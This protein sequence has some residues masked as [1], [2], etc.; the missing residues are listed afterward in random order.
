MSSWLIV[1]V[2][3][4]TAFITTWA[5]LKYGPSQGPD[6]S[7]YYPPQQVAQHLSPG[8][9]ALQG[10]WQLAAGG[11]QI[12]V[13]RAGAVA[14]HADRG[15]CTNCHIVVSSRQEPIP[16]I[17]ASSAMPHEYRGVCSNCHLLAS[18]SGLNANPYRMQ[19][20]PPA[21]TMV[22]VRPVVTPGTVTPAR[23]ATEGEWMGLEVT[24]ITQL[25]ARQYGIPA[26]TGG[27]VVAE[28]EGQAAMVGIKAGDVVVS[29]NGTPI[30]QMTD[31]FQ[32]T[33]NGTLAGGVVEIVRQGTRLTVNLTQT[34]TPALA[35]TPNTT[36]NVA[37]AA[38]RAA[39]L[40]PQGNFS[41]VPQNPRTAEWEPGQGFGVAGR[42]NPGTGWQ[43]QF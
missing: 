20:A 38:M 39:V 26:G 11:T 13:I 36:P 3:L 14:P 25:T 42:N 8:V 19:A 31:F 41:M 35:T 23:T 34:T 4:A 32:A 37:P 30:T 2:V 10:G 21:A 24:P 29:V 15:V 43:R 7:N 6:A 9:A 5:M 28:A 40:M 33:R 12:P 17:R 16:P 27:L 22:A 1:L 18:Q